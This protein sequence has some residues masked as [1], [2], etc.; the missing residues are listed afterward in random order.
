MKLEILDANGNLVDELP[1]SKRRGLNRVN[2]SM[3]TKPPQVPP[4]ASLAFYST[5]GQRVLPG[6]YTVRLTKGGQVTTAPLAV[7]LDRRAS[8][9]VA[10]RQAQYAASER[11]KGLFERMSKLVGQI[12]SVREQAG[13][14]AKAEILARPGEGGGDPAARPRPTR[15]A[16]RSSPPPRAERSP[17]RS[18]C[19]STPTKSTAPSTRSRGA[20]RIISWR[21][22]RRSTGN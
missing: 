15:C 21:G 22:S 18:G 14:L 2:W 4:A 16:R 11:V 17:A 12:N 13:G 8:F 7:T 19:A 9:T 5:Q 10:D 1:A 3:R 6:N 20:R